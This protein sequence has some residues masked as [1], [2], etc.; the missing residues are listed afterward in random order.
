M[1]SSYKQVRTKDPAAQSCSLNQVIPGERVSNCHLVDDSGILSIYV[2]A[3]SVVQ[4]ILLLTP[5]IGFNCELVL[6][7]NL[8]CCFNAWCS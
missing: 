4:L 8:R 6:I 1:V 5:V 7:A 2:T 3:V